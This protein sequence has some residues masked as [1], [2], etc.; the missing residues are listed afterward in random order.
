[1]ARGALAASGADISLAVSGIAGPDGATPDKPVGT[2]WMACHVRGGAEGARLFRFSGG[3][4]AV[5]RRT[6]VAG[7]LLAESALSGREFLDTLTKW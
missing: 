2:V 3:R 1:M 6:A 7:M 4:D 5:R